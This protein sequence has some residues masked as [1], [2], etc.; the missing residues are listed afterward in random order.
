MNDSDA[1]PQG[2]AYRVRRVGVAWR[3]TDDEA[4]VL[5]LAES[6]YYGLNPTGALLWERLADGATRGDLVELLTSS[7]A[8]TEQASGHVDSFLSELRAFGLLL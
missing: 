4:V 1:A 6:V 7:G 2:Q 5:D 3:H 8:P